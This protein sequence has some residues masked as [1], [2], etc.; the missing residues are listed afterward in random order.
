MSQSL[1]LMK[2]L[3]NQIE[4]G[5]IQDESTLTQDTVKFCESL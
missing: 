4:M 2:I 1:F 3:A 5:Y